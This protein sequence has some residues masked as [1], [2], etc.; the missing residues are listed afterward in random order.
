MSHRSVR[1]KCVSSD[2]DLKR[3]FDE[4][5]GRA[6]Y[7]LLITPIGTLVRNYLFQ[8]GNLQVSTI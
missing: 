3:K 1:I 7:Y 4:I 6:E 8:Q 5:S 2:T